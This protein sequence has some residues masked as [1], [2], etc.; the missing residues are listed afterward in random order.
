MFT[1]WF[2]VAGS[3]LIGMALAGSVLKRLPL[4]A[5]MFY[6]TAGALLGPWGAGLLQMDAL[7]SAHPVSNGSPRLRSS[8]R[9]SQPG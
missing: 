3:L 8:S 4:T 2:V 9:C 5:A 7:D 6:L 1:V